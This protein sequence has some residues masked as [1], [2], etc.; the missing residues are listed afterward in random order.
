VPQVVNGAGQGT[1]GSSSM[2]YFVSSQIS[3]TVPVDVDVQDV[4][5]SEYDL[6]SEHSLLAVTVLANAPG[7]SM[8]VSLCPPR[9]W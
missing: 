6:T 1:Y 3:V 5:A 7:L 9:G 8:S 2:G 4:P